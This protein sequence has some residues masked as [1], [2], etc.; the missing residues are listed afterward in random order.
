MQEADQRN[1]GCCP[2]CEGSIRAIGT[3][4]PFRRGNAMTVPAPDIGP[5]GGEDQHRKQPQCG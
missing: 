2:Q 5:R 4:D 1:D 3:A